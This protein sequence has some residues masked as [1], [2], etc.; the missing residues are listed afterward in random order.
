MGAGKARRQEPLD[1]AQGPIISTSLETFSVPTLT[2]SAGSPCA[3]RAI[4]ERAVTLLPQPPEGWDH[5]LAPPR[6]L[7]WAEFLEPIHA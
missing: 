1:L 6:L 4:L 7:Y 3:V 5:S 2:V